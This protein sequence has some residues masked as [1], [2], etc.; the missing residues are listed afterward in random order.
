MLEQK[1]PEYEQVDREIKDVEKNLSVIYISI[2]DHRQHVDQ[3][4]AYYKLI[5]EV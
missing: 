1:H 4:T 5:D 3:T 2:G